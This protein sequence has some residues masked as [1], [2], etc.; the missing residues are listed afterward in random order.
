MAARD[1]V[2]VLTYH[3][4]SAAPRPTCIPLAVFRMQMATLADL[5][6][7][8][9]TLADFQ[10]WRRGEGT[11]ERRVLITFDDG[12]QDFAD[13][14]APVMAEH[15]F[16]SVVF[17]PTGKLG[18]REDW[19]SAPGE[20]QALMDWP[21]VER[22]SRSGVEFGGHSVM[23]RDLTRLSPADLDDEV[24]GSAD[25]LAAH[26]GGPPLGFAPPFGRTNGAVAAAVAA[27]YPLSF[28]TR[29]GRAGRDAP[30]SDI[31]RIEMHYFRDAKRWRSFLVGDDAYL[32]ARQVLRS[33]REAAEAL[34]G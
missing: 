15:G 22:L 4:I 5:G 18:G 16:A 2:P 30:A 14:A 19:D 25:A 20:G 9:M 10:A 31:P 13:A 1:R 7:K 21:T 8:A 27:R 3:S 24:A 26:L 11:G 12:F 28:G 34:R 23:H 17:L 6:F 33:V 29:L 32:G